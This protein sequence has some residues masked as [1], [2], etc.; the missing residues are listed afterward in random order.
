MFLAAFSGQDLSSH[1]VR[2]GGIKPLHPRAAVDKK[3]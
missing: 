1:H 3:N 2:S